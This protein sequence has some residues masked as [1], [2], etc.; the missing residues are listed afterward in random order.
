MSTTWKFD[1]GTVNFEDDSYVARSDGGEWL[2]SDRH[3]HIR[4]AWE[5][6]LLADTGD[7]AWAFVTDEEDDY[8]PRSGSTWGLPAHDQ[9][10]RSNV[11]R[12]IAVR[13]EP[14]RAEQ[15]P[16]GLCSFFKLYVPE[17]AA[18]ERISRLLGEGPYLL[19]YKADN[20]GNVMYS[21]IIADPRP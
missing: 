4:A 15:V 14:S 3:C 13:V 21:D 19:A 20:E 17:S 9:T 16:L 10:G 12:S 11:L 8:R 7:V 1:G 18:K 5:G 6:E 2:G